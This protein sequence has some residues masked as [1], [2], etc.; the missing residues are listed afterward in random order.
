MKKDKALSMINPLVL[1]GVAH[2]GLHNKEVMENSLR[3]FELALEKHVAI[4]LD[5]HIT[6][7]LKLVV[8]HDEDLKRL[9]GQDGI[10]EHLTYEEL[11]KYRLL[12]GQKI[13]LFS[14]VLDLVNEQVPIFVE[15]KVYEKNYKAL[16][17]EVK[18]QFLPRIKDKKNFV[19]ISFDP[20]SLWPLKNSGILRL[21]LVA[22]SH[23]YTFNIT[24]FT[25]D[26]VDL[27]QVL[28]EEERM[29]KY[30]QKHFVSVWTIENKEQLEKV[31][32][33]VDTVTYQYMEPSEVENLLIK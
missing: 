25:V 26:G 29:K 22:K 31:L 7:D 6:R 30:H 33:Y 32:P 4:E 8:I 16:A 18:K 27:E 5:I 21:L 17:N 15:L 20:R 13:P 23:E 24:R 3:A 12:D 11:S 19:F 1:K 10:V 28:F 9:T 14:E 2:R